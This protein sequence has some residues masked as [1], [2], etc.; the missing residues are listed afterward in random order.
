MIIILLYSEKVNSTVAMGSTFARK[1]DVRTPL[2][3]MNRLRSVAVME[4]CKFLAHSRKLTSS[5]N[6]PSQAQRK[7]C[8]GGLIYVP[9]YH[10]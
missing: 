5:C 4:T 8:V 9:V 3:M 10:H 6:A 7:S 2:L 1:M